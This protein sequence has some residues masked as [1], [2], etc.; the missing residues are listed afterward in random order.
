MLQHIADALRHP[1]HHHI[2]RQDRAPVRRHSYPA[3]RCEG[4]VWRRTDRQEVRRIVL[5]ARRYELVGRQAG[6]RTGPLGHIALE[7]LEL[8][9]NLV[10][11][12]TGRLEPA[13]DTMMRKLKRSRDA[14]VR[15]LAALR[16]HGF[17][18]WLRRYEPTE[19]EGPGPQIRQVSNAYRLSL[20]ARAARL[21]GRWGQEV[22]LPDDVVQHAHEQQAAQSA[23]RAALPLG[24]LPGFVVD[25]GPLAR[26]LSA[27]GRSVQER[28]S[29]GRTEPQTT[30]I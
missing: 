1:S 9:G 25:D 5:A 20:P 16:S 26:A 27:L 23:Y 11:Y 24:E 14:V 2:P 21:L 19:R 10:S 8:L 28:E 6:R 18:D 7:V 4:A 17:L 13:I 15:A 12:R 29:A 30:S 3:G 22:P